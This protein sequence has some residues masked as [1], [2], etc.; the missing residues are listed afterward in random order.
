MERIRRRDLRQIGAAAAAFA[1][2]A[3]DSELLCRKILERKRWL[4]GMD[5]AS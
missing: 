3:F 1:A 5:S 4:L 2:R